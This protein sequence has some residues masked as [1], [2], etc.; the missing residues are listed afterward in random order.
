MFRALLAALIPTAVFLYVAILNPQNVTFKLTQTH[1]YS[2]P[3]AAVVVVLVMAGFVAGLVLMA[4]GGFRGLIRR[5]REKKRWKREEKKDSLFHTAMAWWDLRDWS[6]ARRV[7]DRLLSLDA[8]SLDGLVLMGMVAREEGK[9]EEALSWHRKAR[10]VAEKSDQWLLSQLYRDYVATGDWEEAWETLEALVSK[11]KPSSGILEE[12]MDIALQLGQVDKAMSL[13]GRILKMVPK[14]GGGEKARTL[15]WRL[16]KVFKAQGDKDA[17]Y[18][19]VKRDPTFVPAYMVLSEI[20]E[21]PS[22]LI[23]LLKKGCEEN[24]KALILFDKLEGLLLS[25]E[26]PGDL[27]SFYRR[28]RSRYPQE[29]LISF[30]LARLHF[31]LGMYQDAGKVLS[32]VEVEEP[33]VRFLKGLILEKLGEKEG[34]FEQLNNALGKDMGLSYVCSRCGCTTREWREEC[35]GCGEGATLVVELGGKGHGV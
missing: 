32:G 3:M 30:L 34:A 26:K 14:E 18:K 20:E 22:K 7:L 28:L 21:K 10:R 5:T 15:S 9:R 6:K 29:P 13:Q 35:P 16:Y 4:G 17:L 24:P 2:L 25:Q 23:E 33:P 27:I 12:M 19:I 8:H 31:S 1:S 11:G